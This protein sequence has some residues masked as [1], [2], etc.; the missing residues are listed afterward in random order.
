MISREK[1]AEI[2]ANDNP[3]FIENLARKARHLTRTQFGRA[4]SLYAPLYLSNYCDN[5]CTYCGFNCGSSIHRT[6]LTAE[7]MEKEM[8]YISA[9]GI[10]SILLLTGESP[11]RSPLGYLEEAVTL[12][13]RY[14]SGIGLEVYPL[15]TGEYRTLHG[16][17]VDSVTIYQETYHRERYAHYHPAGKKRDYDYRYDTPRRAAEAGIPQLTLGVLLGLHDP[18]EDLHAL[19]CHLEGLM[20][21][22]PGVEYALSVPRI[23]PLPDAPDRYHILSDLD[24]AKVIALSRILFPRAGINL[25][26]R[27]KAVTRDRMIPLG[28]TR[29]SA[30]SKTTVGGYRKKGEKDPQFLVRDQ[31][32]V[33]EIVAMLK[34][35]DL[36]PVF[37]DWRRFGS[38]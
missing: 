3:V 4:V 13:R 24:F 38:A 36:D 19:Y 10:R 27:E 29:I 34:S 5:Y 37:T 7:E 16:A 26:T 9:K 6:R 2:L 21:N 8:A 15:D 25:S 17:G 32:S 31:R 35:R 14:F 30:E 12:A 11:T 33:E 20:K 23:N 22:Y 1:I 28:I 18:A